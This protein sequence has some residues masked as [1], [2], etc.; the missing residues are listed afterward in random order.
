MRA[1]TGFLVM[2][3]IAC[4]PPNWQCD[5]DS[6][7]IDG[8]PTH[9]IPAEMQTEVTRAAYTRLIQASLTY[10][11]GTRAALDGYR[12]I[13]RQDAANNFACNT[14]QTKGCM[15][16]T[17]ENTR[18]ITIEL[19]SDITSCPEFAMLPHEIGHVVLYDINHTDPRWD[20]FQTITAALIAPE[21]PGCEA[22][23]PQIGYLNNA[24]HPAH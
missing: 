9:G 17:D 1:I 4:G 11:G 14:A 20:T 6:F 15:G 5:S 2:A 18:T 22:L 3:C 12:I 21:T 24:V 10:W 19:F 23:A 7:C 13:F 8:V 16:L